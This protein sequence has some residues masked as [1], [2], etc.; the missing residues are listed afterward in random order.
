MSPNVLKN[1]FSGRKLQEEGSERKRTVSFQ[2]QTYQ[3]SSLLYLHFLSLSNEVTHPLM[4]KHTP[5]LPHWLTRTRAHTRSTMVWAVAMSSVATV[6]ETVHAWLPGLM[7][8]GGTGNFSNVHKNV[9]REFWVITI[10]WIFC[11]KMECRFPFRDSSLWRLFCLKSFYWSW[12]E[13]S[14]VGGATREKSS[15][16]GGRDHLSWEH[17]TLAFWA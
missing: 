6:C 9:Q 8:M 3:K 12:C 17:S 5:M 2:A 4:C 15:S 1:G 13:C 7:T 16:W 11:G 10:L 14:A